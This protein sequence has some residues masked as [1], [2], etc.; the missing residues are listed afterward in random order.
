M[1]LSGFSFWSHDIG[2]FV[3]PTPEELYRRWTPFGMLTSH[4]RCHGAPPK[5]PWA[6]GKEFQD[7]FRKSVD[8]KY[9]LMPY[10]YEQAKECTEKGLPM[11]RALF[12]EYPDDP[13][14]WLVDDEYLF[15]RDILVAPLFE[16]VAARNVYLPG[17]EWI[18]Y[19]SGKTYSPGWHSIEPGGIPIV[20]LVRKGAVIPHIKLAQSTQF[21]D[22]SELELKVYGTTANSIQADLYLP[23][24]DVIRIA[25]LVLEGNKYVLKSNPYKDVKLKVSLIK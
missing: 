12:I 13:G 22:W 24:D 17:G 15:G 6:Y 11:M 4:S 9:T 16:A 5:E 2:G 14:A 23:K 21:M 1:G 20:M 25:E 7:E 18:D 3:N 10:I 8:L 19:Q